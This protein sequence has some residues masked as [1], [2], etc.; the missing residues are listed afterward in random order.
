MLRKTV[1]LPHGEGN[2]E[3][4]SAGTN[5]DV[6][7]LAKKTEEALAAADKAA[8]EQSRADELRNI[9]AR[10][11]ARTGMKKGYGACTC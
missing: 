1:T 9:Q 7:N 3:A 5:N 6:A 2:A 4:K 10:A 11:R 8:A